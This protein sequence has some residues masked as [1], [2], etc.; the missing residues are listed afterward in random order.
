MFCQ[1]IIKSFLIFQKTKKDLV[2]LRKRIILKIKKLFTMKLINESRII[3]FFKKISSLNRYIFSLLILLIIFFTW[4]ILFYLPIKEKINN[5]ENQINLNKNIIKKYQNKDLSSTEL[6]NKYLNLIKAKEEILKNT[7]TSQE[8][9]DKFIKILNKN[10]LKVLE[11]KPIKTV[12]KNFYTKEFYSFKTKGSFENIYSFFEE[13]KKNKLNIKFKNLE[14]TK[15][16]KNTISL[17]TNLRL[18]KLK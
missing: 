15:K 17:N 18:I 8:T 10:K 4:F 5:L 1:Y 11:L 16:S 12:Q 9:L 14:L 3:I 2:F 7:N 13:L 6:N